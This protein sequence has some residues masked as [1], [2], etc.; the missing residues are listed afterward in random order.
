MLDELAD[1]SVGGTV[2]VAPRAFVVAEPLPTEVG[3]DELVAKTSEVVEK[4]VAKEATD[5]GAA[6]SVAC[7]E[8]L[9]ADVT[10]LSLVGGGAVDVE[11]TEVVL[12]GT[13]GKTLS[14]IGATSP[15]A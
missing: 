10:E 13:L 12:V 9:E 5:D 15:E 7:T 3:T 4:V 14:T 8:L 11:Y 6:V 2:G 1:P